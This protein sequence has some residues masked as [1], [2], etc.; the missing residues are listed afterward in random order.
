M[1]EFITHSPEQTEEVGKTLAE[2]L[3]G[4]ET[5]VLRGNLGAG[6]TRLTKGIARGLGVT[7]LVTSP[8]FTI[9]NVYIGRLKLYHFDMYRICDPLELEEIGYY[10]AIGDPSGVC[11]IEW[12]ENIPD[13]LPRSIL[14]AEISGS[15]ED[16]RIEVSEADSRSVDWLLPSCL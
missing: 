1:K 16:R 13:E 8:T 2:T 11:V 14:L 6:K 12:A 10:E 5:L 9:Q 4:G 15:G 7:E 3:K